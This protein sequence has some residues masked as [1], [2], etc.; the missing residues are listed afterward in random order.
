MKLISTNPS[1][2]Y[3]P[4]G[5]VRVSTSEEVR[6]AVA[7]A[8]KAAYGWKEIG[9]DARIAYVRS[10]ARVFK[11]RKG[12]LSRLISCEMGMPITQAE[13][14]I[15]DGVAFLKWYCDNA[16]KA[17]DPEVTYETGK[18][19]HMVVR[20]PRGVAAVIVP[21]NFPCTNFIW[22]AGQNLLSGNTI[23]F[24][25][26]EETP[27]F[28]REIERV[29][30][31]AKFPKGV[32]NEIYGDG[33]IGALLAKQS[34]DTICFTGSTKTGR[35]LYAIGAQKMI[36]VHLE[37]GGSSPGILFKDADVDSAVLSIYGF[38]FGCSGQMC[39][40][41]KRLIVHESRF[42]EVV[43]KVTREISR[44]QVGDAEERTTDIGPLVAERQVK[45]LEAQVRD[46][47]KKGAKIVCGGK[48]PA[49]LR[50]AYYEPTVLINIKQNMRVWNEEVFGPVLPII[51][52]KTEAEAVDL[53][54][55]T[56]YGLGAYVYTRDKKLFE[57]VAARIE[58]GMVSMNNTNFVRACNPF[59]GYKQSGLGREHGKYG[60]YEC[61]QAKVIVREK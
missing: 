17:L 60:F 32:F 15:D 13:A 1:R 4:L 28:G 19:I 40:A 20:E 11:K 41:L 14:D 9:L 5:S 33:R 34:V 27:L 50:G 8:R 38:R 37:L 56:I 52:F 59:G 61:T 31:A 12:L 57:R 49:H 7:S 44:K 10:L 30:A 53:A 26:S 2:D 16:H 35:I 39:K 51:S 18:E 22:Q 3:E 48:R 23:V 47:V 55:D 21:W 58:S 43:A 36:P 29:C 24:K 54:N 42:D 25:C 45:L 6:A 46:A